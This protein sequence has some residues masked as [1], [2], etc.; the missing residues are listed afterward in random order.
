MT[1][2]FVYTLDG[3][4]YINLT[5]R[6]TNN[7]VF[8]IRTLKD[9]V[10]GAN[11]RLSSEN[12]KLEDVISQL[13]TFNNVENNEVVF[14]G[15]GEPL[16][17]L[18]EVLALSEYIKTN[19]K[20]VK[21]RVNTNGLANMIHKR[22]IVSELAKNVDAVSVSLNAENDKLYDEISQPQDVYKGAY[23]RVKEFIWYCAQEGIETTATIVTGYKNYKP[24]VQL[25][26]QIAKNLGAK[27]R[28]REWLDNGY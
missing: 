21:I 3:K 2:N 5:N 4:I 19:Y 6:C 12:V 10:D 26:E 7:C 13:K 27:F 24:D 16:I 17:K 8:C 20:N 9:D 25:C 15:Y 18:N 28:V 1:D 23:S 22:N 11:L 14:C